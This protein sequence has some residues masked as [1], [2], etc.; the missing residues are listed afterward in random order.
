MGV[1]IMHYEGEFV[2]LKSI[3]VS[4]ILLLVTL[5]KINLAAVY[6]YFFFC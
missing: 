4:P 5:T 6:V 1:C 3:L 2:T